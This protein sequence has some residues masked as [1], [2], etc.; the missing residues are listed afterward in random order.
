MRANSIS[1]MSYR[2]LMR[3]SA[4][5]GIELR[6]WGLSARSKTMIRLAVCYLDLSRRLNKTKE[7]VL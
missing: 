2:E 4:K 6:R 5:S 3:C 7:E 1:A